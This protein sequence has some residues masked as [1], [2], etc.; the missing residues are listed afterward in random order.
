MNGYEILSS[1]YHHLGN[2]DSAYEYIL[3]YHTLKDSI[4]NKQ[5]LLRIYN[6]K[7]DAEDEKKEARLSLLDKDNKLK[8][9]Q[10]RQESQQKK[11]L[12]LILS[13]FVIAGIFV[14]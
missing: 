10:L 7:K 2:N 12:L 13:A 8:T 1:I 4:Q 14:Y 6:S 9:E 11:F 3:K 5:F